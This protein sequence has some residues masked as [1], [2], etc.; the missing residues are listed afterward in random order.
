MACKI[1]INPSA[2]L[3]II[4]AI[5][6]YN[7]QLPNLGFRF[8]KY[9]QTTLDNIRKNPGGYAVRYKTIRTAI[10]KKFPYMIHYI[11]DQQTDTVRVL[12]VICTHRNPG[13]WFEKT[14]Q[15]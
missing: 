15:G 5:D 12:A 6:W 14:K 1:I 7:E 11:V 8:Y 9:I 4:A 3:D 2:S 13:S 10:V